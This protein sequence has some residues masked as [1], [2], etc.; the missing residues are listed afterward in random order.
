[1]G[2]VRRSSAVASAPPRTG[3]LTSISTMSGRC[4]RAASIAAAPS[5]A[6]PAMSAPKLARRR[7]RLRRTN[8]S[9]STI[10]TRTEISE[11]VTLRQYRPGPAEVLLRRHLH[12]RQINLHDELAIALADLARAAQTCH[13]LAH[14]EDTAAR[15]M[16]RDRARVPHRIRDAHMH[17]RRGAGLDSDR[18]R[19][20]GRM[21][22]R[23]RQRLLHHAEH[24]M[25]ENR[26]RALDP[27]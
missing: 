4:A 9:S 13:T 14:T 15:T 16:R 23:V 3:M 24:R 1:D 21:F 7:V 22:H 12:P 8:G 11:L 25:I 26:G 20:T 2:A 6:S 19:C 27:V 10:R 17:S 5:A 18:Y